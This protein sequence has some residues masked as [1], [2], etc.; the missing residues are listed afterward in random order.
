GKVSG[1]PDKVVDD[2]LTKELRVK[3]EL[4]GLVDLS[5]FPFDK[6]LLYIGL[7][8]KN[9]N[10]T[11]E[12]DEA[13]SSIDSGA[14]LAGGTVADHFSTA[15]EKHKLSDGREISEAQFGITLSRPRLS[16]FFKSIVPVLFMVFVAGFTL[17][18]KPKSAAG[19]L[20]TATGGL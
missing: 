18:L 8:D 14:K 3:A 5:E 19:R 9:E 20:S 10:V 11:Y 2:K 6:H 12:I 13:H 7:I 4:E 1:K 15:A 17:I 16:A